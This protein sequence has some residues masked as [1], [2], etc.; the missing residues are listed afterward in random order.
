MIARRLMRQIHLEKLALV[1]RHKEIQLC[2]RSLARG[3]D[4]TWPEIIFRADR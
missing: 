3:V 4:W 1:M 2:H